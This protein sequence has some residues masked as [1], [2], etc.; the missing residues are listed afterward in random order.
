MKPRLASLRPSAA[1]PEEDSHWLV[2]S[3]LMAT[4]MMIFLFLAVL[5]MAQVE[6][7]HL[8]ETEVRAT[9]AESRQ[10]IYQ[11]LEDEFREDLPRWRAELVKPT[12]TLRFREP[13][14]LF[15][16]SSARIKPEFEAILRDFLPRYLAQLSG[17]KDVIREIRIEGHTSSE[18][19]ADTAP[20]QAYFL[21]MELSQQRTQAVLRFAYGLE[22][23]EDATWFRDRVAAVG[24]SSSRLVHD[25]DGA[26]DPEASRRVEFSVL[27]DFESRLLEPIKLD[28]TASQPQTAPKI[29]ATAAPRGGAG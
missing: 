13:D 4:L 5:H 19:S 8:V 2:V 7:T 16:R 9:A 18:W 1:G 26:E 17:F 6:R 10:A 24:L 3:D 29:G 22:G 27:T 28:P 25:P 12:L 14:V 20:L 23:L 15:D 11:A 21:N